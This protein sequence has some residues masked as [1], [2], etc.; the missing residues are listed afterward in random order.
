MGNIENCCKSDANVDNKN[1]VET[2]NPI[3][4]DFK[5]QKVTAQQIVFIVKLQAI[6]RGVLA[7]KRSR[8]MRVQ[9]EFVV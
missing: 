9:R 7:R 6:V 1:Q 2:V 4:G 5:N 8:L 3:A